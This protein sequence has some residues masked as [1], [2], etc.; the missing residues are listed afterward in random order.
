LK[1]VDSNVLIYAARPGA[2]DLRRSIPWREVAVSVVTRIEV[3][4]YH[5]LSDPEREA[6]E[7]LFSAL[8]VVPV[9][10]DVAERAI[11]LRRRR[12]MSLGDSIIAATALVEGIPLVTHN[13]S[14]FTGIAD[15]Q[16][17]DPLPKP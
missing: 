2:D 15:L 7:A 6:L 10:D 12:R 17:E 1:L 14:D 13:V 5:R 9:S 3:L 16:V 11:E 8:E 4:G